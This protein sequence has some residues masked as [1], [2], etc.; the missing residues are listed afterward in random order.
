MPIPGPVELQRDDI[1][2][3]PLA[4]RRLLGVAGTGGAALLFAP[5]WAQTSVDFGAAGGPST[6][7]ITTAFPQKGPMILQRTSPP[8][9][10]TRFTLPSPGAH[11]LMIRCTNSNGA[12]QPSTQVWN[13]A[14][15]L[16]NTIETTH[17]V[18]A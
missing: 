4:R 10:E 17:V 5:A 2:C 6:R 9:L 14:G 18:A 8:R 15:Y 11:S 1:L 13:P 7:P 12:E 3:Q 16:R